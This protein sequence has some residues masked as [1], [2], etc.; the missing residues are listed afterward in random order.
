MCAVY[1]AISEITVEHCNCFWSL[2]GRQPLQIF[3]LRPMGSETNCSKEYGCCR[4][5]NCRAHIQVTSAPA[6]SASQIL[7][8]TISTSYTQTGKFTTAQLRYQDSSTQGR[9]TGPAAEG[10]RRS[11]NHEE[12]TSANECSQKQVPLHSTLHCRAFTRV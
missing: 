6:V 2:L 10:T 3:L 11:N 12:K 4:K 7:E 8:E 9:K 1:K 5:G